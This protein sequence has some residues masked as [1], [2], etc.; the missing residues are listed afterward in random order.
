MKVKVTYNLPI[1]LVKRLKHLA[2]EED[3]T[4]SE[5]VRLAIEKLI[6]DYEG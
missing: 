2:I 6:K 4:Q 3:K 1:E 5:L